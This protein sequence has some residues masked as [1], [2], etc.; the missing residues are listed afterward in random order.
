M[1]RF[2]G[3]NI[4]S[5]IAAAGL[6]ACNSILGIRLAAD[7][8]W[9][10][11]TEGVL[12]PA[13]DS[14]AVYDAGFVNPNPSNPNLA[15]PFDGA[16]ID[17]GAVNH[18]A[19]WPMPN[20][21]NLGLPNPQNYDTTQAATGI[22]ID[23]VTGLVW[24]Y[25][26]SGELFTFNDAVTHCASL[27]SADDAGGGWRLPSRIELLSILDYTQATSSIDLQRF[28]INITDAGRQI[29]WSTSAK[30]GDVSNAWA[31][32]FGEQT[33]LGTTYP[34][35]TTLFARCVRGGPQ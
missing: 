7:G 33:N 22:V 31:V 21:P 35:G 12:A 19:N 2:R 17:T 28:A 27:T 32:D 26:P 15:P 3:A 9:D 23:N 6:L 34:L 16:V 18:W 24:E 4:G 29:Y 25:A 1:Q 20:P 10:G 8:E 5:T 11:A 13:T 30:A 14:G